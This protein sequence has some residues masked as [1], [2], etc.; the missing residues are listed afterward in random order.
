VSLFG[1]VLASNNSQFNPAADLN[2]DGVIDNSD[3]LLFGRLL[4]QE[5]AGPAALAA[6][7]QL[8][9]PVAG[10][11][12][13][14]EGNFLTLTVNQPSG[15]GPAL[16]FS[17]DLNHDGAFGDAGAGAGSVVSW[18]QLQSLGINDDGTSPL[19]LRVSDGTNALTLP[20]TL[21]MQLVAPTIALSGGATTSEGAVYTLTL[22]AVLDPGNDD[23]V[24][25]YV[26]HWGDGS[27]DT[28]TTA[29]AKTH[30]YTEERS[31][32]PI[33]VDLVDDDGTHPSAGSLSL[34]VTDAV[35]QVSAGGD[36]TIASGQAL[37]RAGSF[38]DPS[39][40]LFWTAT[41]NYGDGGGTQPLSLNPDK[42]FSLSH[43]YL[44]LGD[45]TVTVTVAA[46]EGVSGGGSF[47]VHVVPTTVVQSVVIN[48]GSAQRSMVTGVTITFAG[49]AAVTPG[50]FG[51]S[52]AYAGVTSDVSG[53]LGLTVGQ[54]G[55][56]RTT[57]TLTFSGA[58]VVGGSLPDG[59]YALTVAGKTVP[60]GGFFRLYGDVNGD[61][62]VD[63]ADLAA[64]LAAYRSRKGMASYRAYLD[65]N[66]DGLIDSVDYAQFQRRYKTRLNADGS[67]TQLP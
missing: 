20:T 32:V 58:G 66:A 16:T 7:D 10:G 30:I 22:G 23:T 14:A 9:G 34:T 47:V 36:V 54:T 27:S 24:T 18:S 49:Q 33:T 63:A 52:R 11:Y 12:T 59:R 37:G 1:Q 6:Y 31:P 21:S 53:L 26:V 65:F 43:P 25:S 19:A 15:S 42:S 61:G 48:D 67:I 4:Q 8:L 45:Y 17:W 40:D 13:I 50:L 28:Y 62:Q 2:G 38:A 55:D 57:V 39:A 64:F 41:V 35:P 44:A 5:G 56:G 51:L 3:L 29:G 46:D 60:G